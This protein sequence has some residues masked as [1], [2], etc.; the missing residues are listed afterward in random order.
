MQNSIN[1]IEIMN[2]N[3]SEFTIT[4][5]LP[6]G[7]TLDYI[8]DEWIKIK[9]LTIP[10]WKKYD[11]MRLTDQ[12]MELKID[13]GEL[14]GP[15]DEMKRIDL[16][17]GLIAEQI[18]GIPYYADGPTISLTQIIN[19]DSHGPIILDEESIN[20]A[21]REFYDLRRLRDMTLKQAQI[22]FL[23]AAIDKA[24]LHETNSPAQHSIM[25][26]IEAIMDS[27]IYNTPDIMIHLD[28]AHESIPQEDINESMRLLDTIENNG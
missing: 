22:I 3:H 12:G 7:G 18:F 9:Y 8:L 15:F 1:I 10:R 21:F 23:K 16:I 6:D 11:G 19:E 28:A 24:L 17:I 5:S 2:S 26:T 25:E 14:P 4:S 27:K 20:H 13:I